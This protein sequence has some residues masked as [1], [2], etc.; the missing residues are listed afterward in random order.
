MTKL[1]LNIL[2]A[3]ALLLFYTDAQAQYLED[4]RGIKQRI[5]YGG[6]MGLT[7]G[8]VTV[9]SISPEIGYRLTNRWSAGLGGTYIFY[10][11]NVY[12]ETFNIWGL[13]QFTSFTIIK[14]FSDILPFG[15]EGG[16]LLLYGELNSMNLYNSFLNPS[17]PGRYWVTS[18]LAGL[19]YQLKIGY[20][21]YMLIM[22]LYNFN[23]TMRSPIDNPVFRISLQF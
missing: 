15:R 13:H 23:E 1:V 2:L 6:N 8:S 21:S 19:A 17:E 4:D 3:F 11:D 20:R 16:A 12:D 5:F 9:I 22:V 7:F 10:R 14:N 18:P